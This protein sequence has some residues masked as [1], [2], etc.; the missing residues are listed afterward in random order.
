M[1]TTVQY[2]SDKEMEVV[3]GGGRPT[4]GNWWKSWHFWE[5]RTHHPLAPSPMHIW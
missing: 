2:L 5:P 1:K 3:V 4:V